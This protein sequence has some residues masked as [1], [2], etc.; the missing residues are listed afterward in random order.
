MEEGR[1][2]QDCEAESIEMG[3]DPGGDLF[4]DPGGTLC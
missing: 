3:N 2:E 4:Y 1:S